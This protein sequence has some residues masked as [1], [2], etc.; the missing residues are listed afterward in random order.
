MARVRLVQL[1]EIDYQKGSTVGKVIQDIV[2]SNI[3]KPFASPFD[4]ILDP[5]QNST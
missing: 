3:D 5:D 2:S 4:L 1:D